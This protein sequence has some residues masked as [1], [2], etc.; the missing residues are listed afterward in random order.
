HPEVAEVFLEVAGAETIHALGHLRALGEIG[1]TYANLARVIEEELR[2]ASVMYPR[3]IRQAEGEG[4]QDAA[5]VFR[6]A[7]E[8]ESRHAELFEQ[9]FVRLRRKG[10]IVVPS[11]TVPPRP[12]RSAAEPAAP[13]EGTAE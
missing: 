13:S 1:S 7:F 3:M 9:T 8:G 5:D 2:E 12:E 11:R 10:Q 6:L 4:R